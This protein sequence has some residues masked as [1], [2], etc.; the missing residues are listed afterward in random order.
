MIR[1]AK[2]ILPKW[3]GKSIVYPL[4]AAGAETP[5]YALQ[6]TAGTQG[7][8]RNY[9]KVLYNPAWFDPAA[10]LRAMADTCDFL[11]PIVP[12]ATLLRIEGSPRA[13]LRLVILYIYINDKFFIHAL[14]RQSF[15]CRW[16][17]N[18]FSKKSLIRSC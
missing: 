10:A 13:G 7:W 8:I 17:T 15:M 14:D 4:L 3:G 16:V 9:W 1:C 6:A 12:S 2:S 11:S 5:A 18:N